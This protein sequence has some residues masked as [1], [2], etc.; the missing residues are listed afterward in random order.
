VH[1][2]R[3][4]RSFAARFRYHS[5]SVDH[6]SFEL[7]LALIQEV[8]T[9]WGIMHDDEPHGIAMT[10]LKTSFHV[11]YIVFLAFT[12]I[13][14]FCLAQAGEVR[15]SPD[16]A[17]DALV[18]SP[19]RIL[20]PFYACAFAVTVACSV[21]GATVTVFVNGRQQATLIGTSPDGEPASVPVLAA[22]TMVQVQGLAAIAKGALGLATMSVSSGAGSGGAGSPPAQGAPSNPTGTGA[23]ALPK[24]A[25]LGN[26]GSHATPIDPTTAL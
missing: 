26:I 15:P 18:V 24:Q 17:D 23:R 1:R 25:G 3:V 13:S 16:L 21:P 9:A 7:A 11:D 10:N 5:S 8:Y 2:R 20:S 22:G 19:P 12:M 14:G 4:L 6:V